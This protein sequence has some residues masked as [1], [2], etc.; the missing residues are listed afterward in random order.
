MFLQVMRS[1][2]GGDLPDQ[3]AVC[4]TVH[5]LLSDN[6][7]LAEAPF[8]KGI[9]R[10]IDPSSLPLS[11]CHVLFQCNLVACHLC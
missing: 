2:G 1:A 5:A 8:L 9:L 4:R 6:P 7:A 10:L 11:M 3:M